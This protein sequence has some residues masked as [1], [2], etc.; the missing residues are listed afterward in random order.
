M[1]VIFIALCMCISF[2]QKDALASS[3]QSVMANSDSHPIMDRERIDSNDGGALIVHSTPVSL[4][5]EGYK[6]SEIS[7]SI[8]FSRAGLKKGDIITQIDD[9]KISDSFEFSR[10]QDLFEIKGNHKITI[11]RNEKTLKLNYHT[12]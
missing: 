10:V 2:A 12:K 9:T 6:V 11:Y 1:K 3:E 5:P 7:K 8:F 4:L